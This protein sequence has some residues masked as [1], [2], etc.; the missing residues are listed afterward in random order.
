MRARFSMI[1]HHYYIALLWCGG[2]HFVQDLRELCCEVL[3]S[4]SDIQLQLICLAAFV[5][6]LMIY[7]KIC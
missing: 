5:N 6:P 4:I 1:S 7:L 2:L 3:H